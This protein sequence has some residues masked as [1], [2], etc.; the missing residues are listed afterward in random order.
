MSTGKWAI[1]K[2][3]ITLLRVISSLVIEHITKEHGPKY[4]TPELLTNFLENYC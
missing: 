1:G 3:E 4:I 2:H